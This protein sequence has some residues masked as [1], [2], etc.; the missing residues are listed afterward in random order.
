M[1]IFWYVLFTKVGS[2]K[3]LVKKLEKY[4]FGEKVDPFLPLIEIFHKFANKKT[5]KE[6]KVMFPGYVFIES[7][8]E[9]AI[10]FEKIKNFHMDTNSNIKLLSYGD[11]KEYALR[12]EERILL[13]SLFSEE[14][15]LEASTGVIQ[16]DK[17]II[18]DGPLIGRESIIKKINRHKKEAVVEMDIL[19][20]KIDVTVGL[21]IIKKI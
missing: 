8:F 11:S 9:N 1:Q 10:F 4:F 19:G 2:E 12:E 21:N 5:V 15:T 7:V 17:V 18:T 20:Q 16:G 14:K 3:L 6:Y 13:F